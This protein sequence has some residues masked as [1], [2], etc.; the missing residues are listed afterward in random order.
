ML[1]GGGWEV[2]RKEEAVSEE[3]YGFFCSRDDDGEDKG[4]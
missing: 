1:L 3:T 2:G 4:H